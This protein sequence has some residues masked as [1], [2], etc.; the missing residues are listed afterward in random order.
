MWN[1]WKTYISYSKPKE[2]KTKDIDMYI[3]WHNP[4]NS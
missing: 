3:K 2:V 4:K 1:E